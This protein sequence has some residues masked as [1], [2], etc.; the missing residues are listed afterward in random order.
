VQIAVS[1]AGSDEY[2][3]L[4]LGSQRQILVVAAIY[5][6]KKSASAGGSVYALPPRSESQIV[7]VGENKSLLPLFPEAIHS[8][9]HKRI[10]AI[11]RTSF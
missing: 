2:Y 4:L 9:S 3:R 7:A 5:A 8:V 11:N 10:K 1:S 6:Q